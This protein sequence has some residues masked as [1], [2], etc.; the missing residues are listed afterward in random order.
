MTRILYVFFVAA[1]FCACDRSDAPAKRSFVDV[2]GINTAV[3]PGDNFFRYV[4]GRWYDTV[5]I[6]DDQTGI[7]SYSFL[8][9]PQKLLLQHILDSVSATQGAPGSIEQKV[10]D[11]Y[12]S[13]MDTATIDQR[14][15]E[16]IKPM[17]ARIDAIGDGPSLIKFAATE[18]TAGNSAF[19]G[20]GISPDN[21][22]SSINIAHLVQAGLGL[23]DRDYYFKSDS[24]TL[25]IQKAYVLYIGKLFQLTGSSPAEAARQAEIDYNIEKQIAAAHK[26]RIELRDVNANYN[27]VVVSAISKSQPNIGWEAVFG[28]LDAR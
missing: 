22:N 27:K 13:G 17:L 26:T 11:F 2:G 19:F 5:K 20:F 1:F 12:A 7:G 21:K 6:A 10:G 8:N 23:P 25:R 9:I 24:P 4:N 14:G 18:L 16:P 3:K 28:Y 15:Y